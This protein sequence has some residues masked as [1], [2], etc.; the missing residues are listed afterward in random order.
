M[1]IRNDIGSNA[2]PS[3]EIVVYFGCG[4]Q[5]FVADTVKALSNQ[6]FGKWR[7]FLIFERGYDPYRFENAR[8]T[9]E[10]NSRFFIVSENYKSVDLPEQSIDGCFVLISGGVLLREHALYMFSCSTSASDVRLV[11]SDED[12]LDESG[13]RIQ[14]LFKP[15]YSPEL[16]RKTNYLG[17]SVLLRGFEDTPGRIAEE[18]LK[19]TVT[20]GGLIDDVLHRLESQSIHHIPSVLYH[21]MLAPRPKTIT[22]V[23]LVKSENLLP[24]RR[25]PR[26]RCRCRSDTSFRANTAVAS[27]DVVAPD[28]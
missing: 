10:G 11:Y 6:L 20:I 26:R 7:A 21:D 22:P 1:D 24:L 2:F 28:S 25:P 9:L 12:T 23:E 16:A 27:A 3:L 8:R 5:D 4:T 19:G 13:N 15:Q 18:L 14:P 17:H